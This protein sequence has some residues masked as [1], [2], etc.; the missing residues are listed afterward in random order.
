MKSTLFY[1]LIFIS[2]FFSCKKENNKGYRL[3]D[4][5][6]S[7]NIYHEGDTI[8][9]LSNNYKKKI[10]FVD[11][12][13]TSIISPGENDDW[14]SYEQ[15]EI[16]FRRSD[17][18]F[19]NNFIDVYLIRGYRGDPSHGFIIFTFW[20]DDLLIGSPFN[21]LIADNLDTLT[22]NN[23]LYYN[24]LKYYNIMNTNMPSAAKYIYYQKEKGWLRFE[25]YS[26]ETFDRKN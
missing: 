23:T 3:S 1:S 9:F 4:E 20:I 5:D 26:G 11:K 19:A 21:L 17:S 22:V 16:R 14:D 12:I 7:W 25:L 18:V 8:K 6:K 13:N 15:L 2:L 24:V 10:Y